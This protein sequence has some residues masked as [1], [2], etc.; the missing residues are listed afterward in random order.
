MSRYRHIRVEG[1]FSDSVDKG[2]CTCGWV[3]PKHLTLVC[4]ISQLRDHKLDEQERPQ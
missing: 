2:A 1:H 3:A 4:R